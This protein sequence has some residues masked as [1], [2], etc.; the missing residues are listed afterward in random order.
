MWFPPL[1]S[2]LAKSQWPHPSLS[3]PYRVSVAELQTHPEL[4]TDG[5]GTLSE[6]E[7]QVPLLALGLLANTGP[8]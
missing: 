2:R 6:G 5:D 8:G 4:D 1:T 7:A 3:H